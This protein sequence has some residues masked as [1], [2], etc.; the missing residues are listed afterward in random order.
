LVRWQQYRQAIVV[1]EVQPGSQVPLN[2]PD[3]VETWPFP[4]TV[5]VLTGWSP[6]GVEVGERRNREVNV[7]LAAAVLRYGG[8]FVQGSGGSADSRIAEPSIIA[9]GLER[10]SAAQLAWEA[11]QEAI[12]EIDSE[13][14]RLVSCLDARVEHWPRRQ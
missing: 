10:D 1:A 13:E 2:G 8:R 7:D 14:M 5:H 12:F 6:Q 4:T 3:S 9:W 11:G